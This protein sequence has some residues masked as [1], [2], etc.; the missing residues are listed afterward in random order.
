MKMFPL[1]LAV[2]ATA[3]LVGSVAAQE[4]EEESAKD[5]MEF[6]MYFGGSMPMGGISDWS[7]TSPETGT[8]KIGAKFGFDGGFDVGY[9]LNPNTVI[10]LNVTCGQYS[11]DADKVA[12][13]NMHHRLIGPAVYLK[14]YFQ[15]E[16]SFL[17]YIKAH[18]G[19]DVAKF[20]TRV[21]DS[22]IGIEGS[23]EYREMSYHPA[24]AF[25]IGAGLMYYTFDFGGLYAEANYHMALTKNVISKYEGV[26]YTFGETTSVLDLHA[27]IKVFFGGE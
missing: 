26:E 19:I 20:A 21:F 18:A 27:G 11:V 2:L 17:P 4:A 22:N 25:G 5:F 23:P 12:V 13:K 16:S 15:S 9:F 14:H 10:G 24:F 1:L 7:V 6:A 8:E 3:L